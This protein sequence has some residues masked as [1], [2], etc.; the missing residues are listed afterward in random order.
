MVFLDFV[1]AFIQALQ[2]PCLDKMD[3]LKWFGI[4]GKKISVTDAYLIIIK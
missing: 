4:A 1:G 3:F 2:P